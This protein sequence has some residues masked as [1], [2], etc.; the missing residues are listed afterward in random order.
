[1]Q[2]LRV[3]P[4]ITLTTDFGLADHYVG[5]MKGVLLSRCPDARVVDIS[6]DVPPFSVHAGAYAMDQAAPYFPSGTVHVIVIDP[7]VGTPRKALLVEA[8]EQ[9]FIAPDNGVVS[10]IYARDRSPKTREIANR[11]LWLPV[12][13]HTFHGRD[14]FAPVAAAVASG[15]ARPA[16]VGPLISEIQLLTDFEP[17][18]IV[19]H[20]W[21]GTVLS[22]DRFGNVITNFSVAAFRKKLESK[23]IVADGA[24][25]TMLYAKGVFINRCFDELNLSS[26]QLVKE[27]HQ[28]YVRAGAEVIETNTFGSNRVRLGAFG[29]AEKLRGINETGVRLARDAAGEKAFVAG[30]IGP[31]GTQIEPLGPMSFAEARAV[32]REQAEALVNAGVDLLAI[33]TFYELNELREAI[34]AARE[35]AGPD[36]AIIAQVTVNDDGTLRDGTS[37]ET[38]TRSLNDW[39]VD[40]VGV[41]C[42]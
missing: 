23:F 30:A 26:P 40:V 6:H 7:G 41:N 32:F 17:E 16:D 33:E 1:M 10:M 12:L 35:A 2:P 3:P 18:E 21:R 8:L 14:I 24:M 4:I 34:Y 36:I 28:E 13:S 25:G 11:D 29:I 37:T 15:A 22:I 39:P 27:I 9:Y 5:T 20:F 19:P 38:F 31:L 42:S